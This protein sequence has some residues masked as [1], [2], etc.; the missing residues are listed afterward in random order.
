MLVCKF[1]GSSLADARCFRRVRDIIMADPRRRCI[2]VSAPGRRFPGDYKVTDLLICAAEDGSE[3]G[4]RALMRVKEIFSAIAGELGLR[5]FEK[6]LASLDEAAAM[7]RDMAASRGEWLC[8]LMLAEYLKM[9][10]VDAAEAFKFKGSSP[11]TELTY[12]NIRRLARYGAVIP[13]FYGTDENGRVV[14]FPR[15]GSDICGA[16]AAA[17]LEAEAYENWTDVDGLHAADPA[18]VP[19]SRAIEQMSYAQA[20]LITMM[21]AEV[22]HSGCIAPAE[23]AGVPIIIR[24]TFNPG[25]LGTRIS[26]CGDC[27]F[28]CLAARRCE[29]GEVHITVCRAC[30][31]DYGRIY[32]MLPDDAT[33][34]YSHGLISVICPECRMG[35]TVR[36]IYGCLERARVV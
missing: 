12:E 8:A 23:Q 3:T 32:A 29:G 34:S 5:S 21:G 36:M 9:P 26:K 14:T 13:G 1:G 28:P 10:F 18:L 20:R 35:D 11:D 6:E 17:A 27:T 31:G 4:R 33:C 24:N 30:A 7:G 16:M 15:G 19:G 2:V 25:F 22:L